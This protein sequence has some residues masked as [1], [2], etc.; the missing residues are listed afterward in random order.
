M[1]ETTQQ[2]FKVLCLKSNELTTYWKNTP[3][4]SLLLKTTQAEE[5]VSTAV[6]PQQKNNRK[7]VVEYRTALLCREKHLKKNG[8][9][10]ETFAIRQWTNNAFF[11][12]L[13]PP[14]PI[15]FRRKGEETG[16][17]TMPMENREE[18][19]FVPFFGTYHGRIVV[20]E[21]SIPGMM[22]ARNVLVSYPKNF[23]T[24]ASI[25]QQENVFLVGPILNKEKSNEF[26]DLIKIYYFGKQVRINDRRVIQ[27]R[28]NKLWNEIENHTI[29]SPTVLN[30]SNAITV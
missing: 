9:I 29:V 28:L 7:D 14:P 10:V 16:R 25:E 21:G 13:E 1:M 22:E 30:T 15:P 23:W 6:V 27:R 3:M 8:N 19:R 2:Q 17:S 4:E 5:E 26:Q 11:G 12:Y 20:V 24:L 18:R